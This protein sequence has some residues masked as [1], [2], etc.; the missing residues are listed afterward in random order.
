MW[1]NMEL[2]EIELKLFIWGKTIYPPTKLKTSLPMRRSSF[3]VLLTLR[4]LLLHH[5]LKSD[6][7][8]FRL[9][10]QESTADLSPPA[11]HDSS[12]KN[13]SNAS[14]RPL[15]NSCIYT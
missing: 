15:L 12:C 8:W 6:N 10:K 5:F 9:S 13:M 14:C 1:D 2:T 7:Q 4:K 11:T 3:D